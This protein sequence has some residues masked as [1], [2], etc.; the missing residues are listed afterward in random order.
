MDAAVPVVERVDGGYHI[1]V[2]SQAEMYALWLRCEY[3][4]LEAAEEKPFP[5]LNLS[6]ADANAV[7]VGILRG[8]EGPAGVMG[9]MG[10]P[11]ATA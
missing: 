5:T 1:W 10:A 6:E 7:V 4:P 8:P 11:G 2:G 3:E 9:P